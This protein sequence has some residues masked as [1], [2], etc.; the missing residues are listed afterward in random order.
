MRERDLKRAIERCLATDSDLNIK[1][2]KAS[3]KKVSSIFIC[4]FPH[5]YRP[6]FPR[7]F[8]PLSPASLRRKEPPISGGERVKAVYTI[9]FPLGKIANRK[10]NL[11]ASFRNSHPDNLELV[12]LL[13]QR[14]CCNSSIKHI[15]DLL[16]DNKAV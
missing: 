5:S 11:T 15:Y 16:S 6:P 1:L 9:H 12:Y 3:F 13:F 8:F 10:K 14:L 2:I 4:G 7:A